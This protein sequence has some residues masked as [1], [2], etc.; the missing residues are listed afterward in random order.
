M[1]T[2]NPVSPVLDGELMKIM[3]TLEIITTMAHTMTEDFS[4]VRP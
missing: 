1:A 4:K 3:D 2:T